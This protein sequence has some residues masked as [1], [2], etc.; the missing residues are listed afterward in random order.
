MNYQKLIVVGNVTRDAERKT[1]KKGDVDYT[2]FSVAVN[3]S[4]DRTTYFPITLFGRMS[5]TL[6]EYITKGRQILVEGR[7][8]IGEKGYFSVI[9]DRVELGFAPRKAD[10]ETRME[11][12][13][14]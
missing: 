3:D 6:T 5:E 8:S 2:T 14:P 7:V 1:S 10:N 12:D 4:K 11:E 13:I 9:A